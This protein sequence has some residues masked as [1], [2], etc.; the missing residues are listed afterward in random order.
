MIV[1]FHPSLVARGGSQKYCIDYYNHFKKKHNVLLIT[2]NYSENCYPEI[3]REKDIIY[4]QKY[5][6]KKSNIKP[7]FI[8]IF[9]SFIYEIILTKK[10][11]KILIERKIKFSDIK[12]FFQHETQFNFLCG[13]LGC[14]K[15]YLFLYDSKNK[16]YFFD[17][18]KDLNLIDNLSIKIL[19]YLSNKFLLKKYNKIFVLEETQKKEIDNRYNLNSSIVYGYFNE[20]KFFKL[21]NNI[22]KDKF[23]LDKKTTIIFSLT[24]FS[25]YKN[26][27]DIFEFYKK[28]LLNK[29]DVFIYIKAMKDDFD[30]QNEIFFKYSK[31]IYP[32][33]N[34]YIDD[35]TS[36]N[37]DELF[38]LYNSSDIFIFSSRNQTWGNAILESIAC[39]QIPIISDECG[40][41][42]L[43]KKHNLGKVYSVKNINELYSSF[44]SIISNFDSY[45]MNHNFVKK[46]LTFNNHI[47]KITNYI[48]V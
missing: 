4:A 2:Y 5:S 7:Y 41:N 43:I 34:I 22:L 1:L 12:I 21:K 19:Y 20:K 15:N 16:L 26:I 46:E 30:Y 35:T 11:I 18:G 31:Y 3:I 17:K 47:K 25:R 9:L 10:L 42:T 40:I 44:L 45:N 37:E 8:K 36:K 33:G 48:N 39:G 27:E 32:H 24:R 14:Y 29:N 6:K 28:T 13:S 38:E 23:N